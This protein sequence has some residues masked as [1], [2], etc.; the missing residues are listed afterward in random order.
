MTT[1]APPR[2][3]ST[4]RMTPRVLLLA[5]VLVAATLAVLAGIG[6]LVAGAPA[7]WGA[8]VGGSIAL[9]FLALGSLVV[10]LAAAWAPAMS[11]L[12]AMMTFTLQ[13]LLAGLVF[14]A[15]GDSALVA[16]HLSTTW[17]AG[18]VVVA[19]L[20]WTVAQVVTSVRARVAVYDIELPGAPG[21]ASG[22]RKA[23]VR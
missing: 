6:A 19:A 11:L 13:V 9:L 3:G 1:T 21:A 5:V 8:L 10:S 17:L 4:R 20:S 22:P 12:V 7:A 23:G 16:R 18:G 2:T 14:W 15:L